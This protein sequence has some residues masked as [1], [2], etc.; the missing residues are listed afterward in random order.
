MKL[1]PERTHKAMKTINMMASALVF[2]TSASRGD[3]LPCAANW[4]DLDTASSGSWSELSNWEESL[5]QKSIPTGANWRVSFPVQPSGF[6][7]KTVNLDALT[8]V[9]VPN[10]GYTE[11]GKIVDNSP[12][13]RYIVNV[14]TVLSNNG[15]VERYARVTIGDADDFHGYWKSS[16]GQTGFVLPSTLS[17]TRKI[18]NVS[19]AKDIDLSVPAEGTMAKVGT[20]YE[21]GA[22][23]KHGAGELEVGATSGTDT[24][25]YVAE[26]TL[27]LNGHA[28]IRDEG[29]DIPVPAAYLHLDASK[30]NGWEFSKGADGRLYVEKWPAREWSLRLS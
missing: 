25:F 26:G 8:V 29:D 18:S 3:G 24:R 14:A 7:L 30:T 16:Y 21:G 23:T 13:S 19:A 4:I 27:T 20:V 6:A 10:W 1:K 28:Q 12:F 2:L 15:L 17:V 22:G 11:I 9:N 5:A